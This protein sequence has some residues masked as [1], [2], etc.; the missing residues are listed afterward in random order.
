M[1]TAKV[2]SLAG[3]NAVQLDLVQDHPGAV[4]HALQ[5]DRQ[6]AGPAEQPGDRAIVAVD[7][8]RPHARPAPLPL[9]VTQFQG[10]YLTDW[11][12]VLAFVTLALIPAVAF[13]LV[14]ERQLIAGLTAGSV[15]G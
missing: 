11:A 13:Y 3:L 1:T 7:R 12:R 5:G 2:V 15:K 4:V 9:G 10:Q 6:V 8:N 14:A